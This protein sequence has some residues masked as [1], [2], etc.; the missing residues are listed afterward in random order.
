MKLKVFFGQLVRE[1]AIV[2]VNV[3]DEVMGDEHETFSRL[4]RYYDNHSDAFPWEPDNDWGVEEG[5][6]SWEVIEEGEDVSDLPVFELTDDDDE[7]EEDI[8]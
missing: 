6:H 2:I 5:D 8:D 7:E 1:T 4:H 3:P